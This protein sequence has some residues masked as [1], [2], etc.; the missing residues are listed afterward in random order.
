[1]G[2]AHQLLGRERALGHLARRR[3]DAGGGAERVLGVLLPR[4]LEPIGDRGGFA[5][6]DGFGRL[7]GGEAFGLDADALRA[8]RDVRERERSVLGGERVVDGDAVLGQ[9]GDRRGGD[10]LV[11]GARQHAALEATGAG[12]PLRRRGEGRVLA[13]GRVWRGRGGGGGFERVSV[14]DARGNGLVALAGGLERELADGLQRGGV[15]LVAGRADHLRVGQL[16]VGGDRQ[17]DIDRGAL[18]RRRRRPRRLD[19]LRHA[20]RRHRRRG[21]RR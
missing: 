2:G 8:G 11:G 9:Q 10:G 19:R 7:D 5:G 13:R 4:D 1:A 21:R 18:G 17:L 14:T 15:Q 12:R 3:G 20:R 6:R 16:A